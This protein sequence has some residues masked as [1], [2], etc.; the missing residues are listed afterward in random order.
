M[1]ERG[2]PLVS[3]GASLRQI[4]HRSA[5]VVAP[6]SATGPRMH[7][8]ANAATTGASAIARERMP[9][10][11]IVR[12]SVRGGTRSLSRPHSRAASK[13]AAASASAVRAAPHAATAL[14]IVWLG[15]AAI[16][17]LVLGRSLAGL[18]EIKRNAATLDD[19]V[20]RR[21]RRW[22]QSTRLGRPVAMRVSSDVDVPVAVGFRTPAIL[23]PARVVEIEGVADI[24]Q[25]AMHEY[26]HLNRYDD[27][28][29]L[30]QRVLE[31]IFWFNPVVAF[32]GRRIALE[33][34]IACDDWVIAQTGRAHRYATC[35]WKLVESSRLPATPIVAPGA[36]LTPRQITIR[37]E[38]LLD[39]RRNALPR[40]S[41]LGASRS[42][43][44]ARC[45][46][47]RTPSARPR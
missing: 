15:G 12:R 24:D 8:F 42:G 9:G 14:A 23:L 3:I 34:E 26:A 43:R 21:L 28:T 47:S 45:W 7:P 33:R 11:R 17:L 37:I 19:A 10:R 1:V 5:Q 39:S 31:R 32:V 38:Q 4:E 16:G 41:P 40:L 2:L 46:R 18:R 29:N 25:I 30:A 27:W 22:R 35:L 36:L 6:A 44:C 13:L 20:V